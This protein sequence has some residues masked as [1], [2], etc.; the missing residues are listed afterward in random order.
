MTEKSFYQNSVMPGWTIDTSG[1]TV[2]CHL[3]EKGFLGCVARKCQWHLKASQKHTWGLPL[4]TRSGYGLTDQLYCG[5]MRRESP[6]LTE[7]AMNGCVKVLRI[8]SVCGVVLPGII[9]IWQ[10]NFSV[11]LAYPVQDFVFFRSCAS[12][13]TTSGS[14]FCEVPVCQSALAQ[15]KHSFW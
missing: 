14:G 10:T 3:A 1:P 13:T 7:K 2:R 8:C 15:Y 9:P 5:Q 12:G 11:T 4:S 6:G